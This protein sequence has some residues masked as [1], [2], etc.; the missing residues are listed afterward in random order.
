[1]GTQLR[2]GLG[3]NGVRALD[4]RVFVEPED[5]GLENNEDSLCAVADLELSSHIL[6]H[7]TRP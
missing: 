4:K 6:P 2:K 7:T 3:G 1:M 5:T